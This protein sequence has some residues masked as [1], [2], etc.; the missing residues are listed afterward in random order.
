LGLSQCESG[1][2][3]PEGART[4]AHQTIRE[5]A[6]RRSGYRQNKGS[7]ECLGLSIVFWRFVGRWGQ[8][9]VTLGI[10]LRVGNSQVSGT[11]LVLV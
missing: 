2:H 5:A 10:E 11:S 6:A 1:V 4:L 7:V 3:G 8:S 9:I